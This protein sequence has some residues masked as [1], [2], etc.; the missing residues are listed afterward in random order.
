[1]KVKIIL[2]TLN[3]VNSNLIKRMKV[4]KIKMKEGMTKMIVNKICFESFNIN[5]DFII[6]I[7]KIIPLIMSAYYSNN[8]VEVWSV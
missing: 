8:L 7:N 2:I 6:K 4:K 1:M 5:D 3:M